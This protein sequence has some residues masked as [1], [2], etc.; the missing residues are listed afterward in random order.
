MKPARHSLVVVATLFCAA[1]FVTTSAKGAENVLE[2]IQHPPNNPCNW[3]GFYLGINVGANWNH[4]DLG[5]QFIRIVLG[6]YHQEAITSSEVSDYLG[7][8]LKHLPKIERA[9]FSEV[10][11]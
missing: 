11:P 2:A 6:A 7:T 3:T 8:R 4:F 5:K 1:I 10:A 9:V